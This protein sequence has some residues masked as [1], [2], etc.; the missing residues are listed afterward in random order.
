MEIDMADFETVRID[1]DERGVASL[2]LARPDKHNALDTKMIGELR[3]AAE[4]L[5]RDGSVRA[6]VLAGE[7]QS[8]CAGADLGW[9]RTQLDKDRDSKIAESRA[10]ALMLS[11]LDKLPKPLIG[12]VHGNAFG[13]GIGMMA[14]CDIVI[15]SS[16]AVFALTETRL[17]L[18]PA[19]IG[20]YV[21]RRMGEGCARRLFMNGKRFDAEVAR[22]VGLVSEVVDPAELDAAIEA[23]LGWILD[24]AP[25]AVAEAKELC[26][27]LSRG[28][29]DDPLA[30]TAARLADRWETAEAREGIRS[31]FA[32]ER[33]PWA[34][35]E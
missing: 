33:P 23:E 8:F 19:T 34:K 27:A 3:S 18:I 22:D 30:Y 32:R 7:G 28:G 29:H 15:A 20:P 16:R 25:G 9:M 10:L 35:K 2:W 26:L 13:G 17:G 24:C 11:G 31:F 12:R 1:V 21:V 6:V 5:A 4:Q 14:V